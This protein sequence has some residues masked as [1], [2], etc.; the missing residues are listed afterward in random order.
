MTQMNNSDWESEVLAYSRRSHAHAQRVQDV[1]AQIRN[2]GG[3]TPPEDYW[4]SVYTMARQ[5]E[6]MEGADD[7]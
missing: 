3:A 4:E 7:R 6:Q 2:E 1:R 5:R